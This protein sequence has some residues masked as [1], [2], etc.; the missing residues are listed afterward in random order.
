MSERILEPEWLDHLDAADPR[1]IRARRELRLVNALMG[2]ARFIARA[3]QGEIGDG[4]HIAEL[5]AGDGTLML[6]VARTL[7]P[8]PTGVSLALVDRVST[9]SDDTSARFS[10]LGWRVEQHAADAADWLRSGSSRYDAICANLFLHHLAPD[11]LREL[12]ALSARRARL[13]VACEP[14]R[15][16]LALAASRALGLIGCGA[17]TRHDAVVSVRA[18]FAGSELARAWPSAAGWTVEEK[19]AGLFSHLFRSLAARGERE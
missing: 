17:E 4:A 11:A 5:G 19:R 2:N 18:G 7:R 1:A 6:R 9:V 10:A 15:S 12:F 8:R 16:P 13:F 14:L 3:L